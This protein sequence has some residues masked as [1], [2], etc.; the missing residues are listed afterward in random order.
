MDSTSYFLGHEAAYGELSRVMGSLDHQSECGECRPCLFL[1][2][3]TDYVV[4]RVSDHMTPN[5]Q[6]TVFMIFVNA[7]ERLPKE[8]KWS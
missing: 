2:D 3:M 1:K 6:S 5:E 7:Y 8:I 4:S